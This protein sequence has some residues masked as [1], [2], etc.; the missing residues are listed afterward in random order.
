MRL[1]FTRSSGLIVA[2]IL[3]G[4][5]VWP[6]CTDADDDDTSPDDDDA[7]GDDDDL[8]DDDD[9]AGSTATCDGSLPIVMEAEENGTPKLAG[10][11]GTPPN[12]GFCVEGEVTCGDFSY[13]DLDLFRLVLPADRDVRFVLSW[14][15]DGDFDRYVWKEDS[16]DPK[17]ENW[18]LGF[19]NGASSPEDQSTTLTAET[20][21]LIE[22]GCWSGSGG[23]YALEATYLELTPS[24]DDD[25]SAGDDDD[26][27][28]DDDDSVSGPATWSDV[29]FNVISVHCSCHATGNTGG[30]TYN[31]S[32]QAGYAA[33]VGVPSQQSSLLRVS[34]NLSE[35]SYLVHKLDGTQGSVG[36]GGLQMP[37]NTGPLPESLRDMV[38]E[39]IDAGAL[40]D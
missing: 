4:L 30:W 25:D 34:P 14:S 33:M 36:G 13:A 21:Y 29:Y 31:N 27:S 9:S 19:E 10:D 18:E 22:V 16:Y 38:R 23:S 6:G 26:S 17:T 37:R 40:N 24:G 35:E 7:V 8:S 28:G 3:L 11:I 5:F 32:S 1:L 15:G 20:S 2:L 12:E 39:W